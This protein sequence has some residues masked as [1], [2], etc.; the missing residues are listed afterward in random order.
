MVSLAEGENPFTMVPRVLSDLW[1]T[2]KMPDSKFK[3]IYVMLS[4]S[5]G[6]QIKRRYLEKIFSNSTLQKYLPEIEDEG[7]IRIEKVPCPTGGHYKVYHTNRMDEWD[8]CK[9]DD[10]SLGKAPLGKASLGK[11]SLGKDLN[12]TKGNE[13]KWNE[14]DLNSSKLPVD[15]SSGPSDL[16][17]IETSGKNTTT[18]KEGDIG[19]FTKICRMFHG[20]SGYD[21]ADA[22]TFY[23]K[24]RDRVGHNAFEKA[25]YSLRDEGVFHEGRIRI[26]AR[27]KVKELILERV[28]A[29]SKKPFTNP[30][31]YTLNIDPPEIKDR[32]SLDLCP[33]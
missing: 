21:F 6:F 12:E 1:L 14:T 25:V 19:Y 13:T 33:F 30:E 22:R 5:K 7:Y 17:A 26:E 10:P 2:K 20:P 31:K 24:I 28:E 9:V 29:K 16:G 23:R 18:T 11:A 15:N 27:M 4:H 3:L 32:K 8:I